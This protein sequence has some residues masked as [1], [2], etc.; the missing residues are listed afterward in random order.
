MSYKTPILFKENIQ[1][2]K[3]EKHT[4]N[5]KECLFLKDKLNIRH[6]VYYKNNTGDNNMEITLRKDS[7]DELIF[8]INFE[9]T[10]DINIDIEEKRQEKIINKIIKNTLEKLITYK[11]YNITL[12][13]VVADTAENRIEKKFNKVNMVY[14]YTINFDNFKTKFY[15]YILDLKLKIIFNKGIESLSKKNQEKIIEL[16]EIILLDLTKKNSLSKTTKELSVYIELIEL[17]KIN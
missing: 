8:V 15:N 1:D 13:S 5:I 4:L 2:L 3:K 6:T 11:T 14:N 17:N 12:N 10:N 16:N 7:D 9:V